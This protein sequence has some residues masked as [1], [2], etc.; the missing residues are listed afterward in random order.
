MHTYC[1]AQWT[2]TVHTQCALCTLHKHSIATRYQIMIEFILHAIPCIHHTAHISSSS[3][4]NAFNE[5]FRTWTNMNR[6]IRRW[7]S[8]YY[9]HA[10]FALFVVS[11]I[12]IMCIGHTVRTVHFVN[13]FAHV[14]LYAIYNNNKCFKWLLILTLNQAIY[15]NYTRP[16]THFSL[17]LPLALIII[18]IMNNFTLYPFYSCDRFFNWT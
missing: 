11:D 5:W 10:Y 9:L 12:K 2:R 15:S 1:T 14:I 13:V 4:S 6:Q 18:I 8:L 3:C 7:P 16:L 17:S